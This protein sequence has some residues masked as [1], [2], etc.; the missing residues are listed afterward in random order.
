MCMRVC[1]CVHVCVH[2]CVCVCVCVRKCVC[3]GGRVTAD[4]LKMKNKEEY[5]TGL[6]VDQ[7]CKEWS[8]PIWDGALPKSP[9][10][11]PAGN[12]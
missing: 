6:A 7:E 9:E 12:P 3:G 1:V 11:T 8:W 5:Y 4:S 10:T 2:V